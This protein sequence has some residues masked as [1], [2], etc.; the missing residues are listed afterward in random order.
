M[1]K[2]NTLTGFCMLIIVLTINA[3]LESCTKHFKNG[4]NKNKMQ[5]SK[6]KEQVTGPS[7]IIYKT[8]NDYYDLVPVT[9]SPDKKSIVSFPGTRDV[10]YK[11]KLAYP[12][13]L[14]QGF[15]LDNRGI[16]ENV[17]FLTMTYDLFSKLQKVFSADEL[18]KMIKDDDPLTEMYNCG[19]RS[20]WDIE[21]LNQLIDSGKYKKF[22]RLK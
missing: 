12:E 18:F 5:L 14:H 13:R 10:F 4:K 15:L 17:A 22:K 21:K 3:S 11:G 20:Q 7:T 19:N 16:N 2:I 1:K 9:L 8:R 6:N